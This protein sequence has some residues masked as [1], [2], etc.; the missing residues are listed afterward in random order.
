[1]DNEGARFKSHTRRTLGTSPLVAGDRGA[2]RVRA[3]ILSS[4]LISLDAPRSAQKLDAG[5]IKASDHPK[6]R[7]TASVLDWL[8]KLCCQPEFRTADCQIWLGLAFVMP[9]SGSVRGKESLVGLLGPPSPPPR[10][11]PLPRLFEA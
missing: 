5:S 4:V 9:K 10:P 8:E 1:M 6:P 11:D 3:R 7:S 2:P